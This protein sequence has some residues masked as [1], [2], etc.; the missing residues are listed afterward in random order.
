MTKIQ[1]DRNSLFG[2][3][4]YMSHSPSG[5][6]FALFRAYDPTLG[7]WINRDPSGEYGGVNLYGYIGENPIEFNDPLGLCYSNAAGVLKCLQAFQEALEKQKKILDKAAAD[8][9]AAFNAALNQAK[10]VSAIIEGFDAA[11]DS[12]E[13]ILES[14]YTAQTSPEEIEGTDPSLN[15]QFQS[16]L[17]SMRVAAAHGV[18]DTETLVNALRIY[19]AEMQSIINSYRSAFHAY[20]EGI[21]TCKLCHKCSK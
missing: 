5:L 1:G 16:E 15:N 13:S 10:D 12:I 17:F 9:E 19:N 20:L 3:A 7:R 11:R 6:D 18:P 4:G 21:K 2:Y 14:A 8:A